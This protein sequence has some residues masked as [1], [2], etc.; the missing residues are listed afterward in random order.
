[1]PPL[2]LILTS[3][4]SMGQYALILGIY[5]AT[6]SVGIAARNLSA[7][8]DDRLNVLSSSLATSST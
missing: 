7:F 1:M 4:P 5:L 3:R 2:K 8:V 6:E